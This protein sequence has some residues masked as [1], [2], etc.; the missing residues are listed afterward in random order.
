MS[1]IYIILFILLMNVMRFN[2]FFGI[3]AYIFLF[4][5]LRKNTRRSTYYQSGNGGYQRTYSNQQQRQQDP[6]VQGA[7]DIE[8]SEEEIA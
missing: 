8:F 4:S 1:I 7:I 2:F 3:I 5:M 6:R